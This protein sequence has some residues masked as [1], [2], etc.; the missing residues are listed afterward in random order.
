MLRAAGRLTAGLGGGMKTHWTLLK[1]DSLALSHIN[2]QPSHGM[3]MPGTV[4]QAGAQPGGRRRYSDRG[5]ADCGNR[6]RN[7][8]MQGRDHFQVMLF[9]PTCQVL[10][11]PP[12]SFLLKELAMGRSYG[13]FLLGLFS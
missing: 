11:K 6:Q 4:P 7:C 9:D 12:N 5:C 8:W 1:A 2:T 3:G 13:A 10:C